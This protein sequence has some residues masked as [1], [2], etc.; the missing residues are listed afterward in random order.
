[1]M[2]LQ[3]YAHRGRTYGKIDQTPLILKTGSRFRCNMIAAISNQGFM[4]WMGYIPLSN[5]FAGFYV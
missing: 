3:S 2:G 5:H 1:M 4:K